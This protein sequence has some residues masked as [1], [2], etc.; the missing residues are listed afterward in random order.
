MNK[1]LGIFTG[2]IFLLIPIYVWIIDFANFG[3]AALFL[4][5]GG[6]I[7]ISL[8]IGIIFLVIGLTKLKD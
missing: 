8:G 1:I 3:T 4:L 5:K 6:M 2:L 7:W